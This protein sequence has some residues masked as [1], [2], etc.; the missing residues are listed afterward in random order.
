M[1]LGNLEALKNAAPAHDTPPAFMTQVNDIRGQGSDNA[2][3]AAYEGALIGMVT[4]TPNRQ[5]GRPEGY[6]VYHLLGEN[7]SQAD[8]TRLQ[9]ELNS[10]LQAQGSSLR[11]QFDQLELVNCGC[12]QYKYQVHMHLNDSATGRQVSEHLCKL[13]K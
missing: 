4:A 9:T 3:R 12:N 8:V 2:N 7:P 10:K 11:F 13:W 6:N 1:V 5:M